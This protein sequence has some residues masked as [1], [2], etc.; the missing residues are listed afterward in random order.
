MVHT[1]K[2]EHIRNIADFDNIYSQI[3]AKCA[4]NPLKTFLEI[5]GGVYLS[6]PIVSYNSNKK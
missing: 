3:R 6:L 2:Y 4:D 5:T 1:I